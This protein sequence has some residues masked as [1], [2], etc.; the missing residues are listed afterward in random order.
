MTWLQTQQKLRDALGLGALQRQR[1][2]G[3]GRL[4]A[5]REEDDL[6]VAGS[7]ARS[8]ARRAASRPSARRRPAPWRRAACTR[9]PG[10]RS[11]SPKQVKITPLVAGDRDA[12]VDPA[13]RD[14]ADR[15]AGAV[16][17]LDVGGQQVV[18]PVLVDRV[19]VAA[20]DLHH[21]VV[22]ARLDRGEDLAGEH[23]AELR[24]RGTRRRTSC[25]ALAEVPERDAG[26]DEHASPGAT[27]STSSTATVG[28]H[29]AVVVGAERAAARRARARASRR[30]RR[31]R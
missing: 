12:V 18:D 3:R 17:E 5:D 20:A 22:A 24:R 19:G 31:R 28:A 29:G 21:L 10:T 15:A 23:P 27:G 30:P 8:A 4:E 6:A 7:R 26:V 11:M 14:H 1:G 2:R 25:R 16:D 13:H 9:E